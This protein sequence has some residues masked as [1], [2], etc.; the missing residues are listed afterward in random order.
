VQCLREDDLSLWKLAAGVGASAAA[1]PPLHA[2]EDRSAERPHHVVN[3]HLPD[4]LIG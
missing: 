4:D 2:S 3:D 1:L